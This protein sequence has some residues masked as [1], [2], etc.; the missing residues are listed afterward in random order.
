MD[1]LPRLGL[2]R[3]GNLVRIDAIPTLGTGKVDLAAVRR[4][5][6]EHA[7]SATDDC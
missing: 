6:L 1:G 5:A 7:A 2:P 3:R 4:L